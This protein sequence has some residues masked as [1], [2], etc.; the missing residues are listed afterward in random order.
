MPF[1][2]NFLFLEC[3]EDDNTEHTIEV[4]KAVSPEDAESSEDLKHEFVD[5]EQELE[6][7]EKLLENILLNSG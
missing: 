1:E 3:L 5:A 4:D 2:S 6:K 7:D